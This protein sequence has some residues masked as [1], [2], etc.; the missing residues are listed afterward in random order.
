M[1]GEPPT[2]GVA[3][4]LPRWWCLPLAL[5]LQAAALLLQMLLQPNLVRCVGKA[6]RDIGPH[7][8]EFC[9]G[10]HDSRASHVGNANDLAGIF[11]C[12]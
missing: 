9:S 1:E 8:K 7:Q 11:W 2:A 6:A 10:L 4:P 12:R 3:A 5:V